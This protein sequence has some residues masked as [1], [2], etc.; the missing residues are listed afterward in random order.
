MDM[1]S[2]NT[3]RI[4]RL[5]LAGN[6]KQAAIYA[7]E[8]GWSRCE[9][10]YVDREDQVLGIR[11]AELHKVGTWYEREDAPNILKTLR[12]ARITDANTPEWLP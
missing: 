7:R 3:R 8:K 4:L 9:W 6:H 2:T 5:V 10:R 12:R 11:D 1:T